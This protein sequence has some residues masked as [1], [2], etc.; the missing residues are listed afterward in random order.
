MCFSLDSDSELPILS[1]KDNL[2]KG[3]NL[4]EH[5]LKILESKLRDKRNAVTS[6][7]NPILSAVNPNVPLHDSSRDVFDGEIDI[8]SNYTGFL[9][10]I[11]A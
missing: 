6:D 7:E 9:E 4:T 11:G 10:I 2:I 8:N 3:A 1:E 5:A